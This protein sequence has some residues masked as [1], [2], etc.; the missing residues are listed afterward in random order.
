[1]SRILKANTDGIIEVAISDID[2]ASIATENALAAEAEISVAAASASAADA[3]ISADAAEFHATEALG[4]AGEAFGSATLAKGAATIAE[5]AVK[6]I[7]K[8][9]IFISYG[10]IRFTYETGKVSYYSGKAL[11]FSSIAEKEYNYIIGILKN[12]GIKLII[13]DTTA[14]AGIPGAAGAAGVNTLLIDSNLDLNDGEITN[15]SQSPGSD[16]DAISAKFYWDLF[17]DNVELQWL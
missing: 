8:Y 12:A 4:S 15:I 14:V 5:E 7:S 3:L 2:Y 1:M 9:F 11:A 13:R 6:S 16:Y 17:N 10:M